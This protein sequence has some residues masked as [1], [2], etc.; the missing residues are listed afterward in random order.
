MRSCWLSN[1]VLGL[2]PVFATRVAELLGCGRRR[3]YGALVRR[4][5]DT[6]HMCPPHVPLQQKHSLALTL[7]QAL[8]DNNKKEMPSLSS[9][10]WVGENLAGQT[11]RQL[12]WN[13][14]S[15]WC[16][17]MKWVPRP[18]RGTWASL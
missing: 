13:V 16:G 9:Q 11:D 14:L 8:G 3:A 12:K 4:G 5:L 15:L 1:G 7:C 2:E 17:S 6:Y 18:P 10:S